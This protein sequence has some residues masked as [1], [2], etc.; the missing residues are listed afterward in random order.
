MNPND[1]N[2]DRQSNSNDMKFKTHVN[3]CP[4]FFDPDLS[5]T[6]LKGLHEMFDPN[7]PQPDGK[8]MK[9]G[10]QAFKSNKLSMQPPLFKNIGCDK[11]LDSIV[12]LNIE[13]ID[14][15]K[16]TPGKLIYDKST[17]NCR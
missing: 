7:A 2:A 5:T 15:L 4:D 1:D 11:K 10:P 14:V 16:W 3:F 12:G 9:I 6:G 17:S 13:Q 8:P